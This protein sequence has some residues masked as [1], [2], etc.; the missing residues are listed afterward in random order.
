VT[1]SGQRSGALAK[2]SSRDQRLREI[3]DRSADLFDKRGYDRVSMDDIA[4]A[5]GLAKP[6]LY[7]YVKSKD[8]ILSLIHEEFMDFVFQT[9]DA[10]SGQSLSMRQELIAVMA[11]I[12]GLMRSHRGHV[13]V[14][15]EHHRQL[16]PNARRSIAAQRDR[17]ES[18]VRHVIDMG[19]R[20]G[21]FKAVDSRLATLALFGMCN[22]AY[23]WY[24]SAGKLSPGQIADR[25][26]TYF[27][28]GIARD[29]A[30][31]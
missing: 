17:Y 18:R 3:I 6:S 27:L 19:I 28:Y 22:W 31:R 21:E 15:F 29:H 23:Q 12:L 9:Y 16:P 24:D 13:R 14:F 8:N 5:V 26:G 20:S 4:D 10:R 7:H 2:P 11:D 25:F 30:A 1:A